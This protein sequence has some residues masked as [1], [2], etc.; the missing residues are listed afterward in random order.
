MLIDTQ[1][2]YFNGL[3]L[4]VAVYDTWCRYAVAYFALSEKRNLKLTWRFLFISSTSSIK[5]HLSQCCR[6]LVTGS[7]CTP[8]HRVKRVDVKM[9]FV[10]LFCTFTYV[11]FWNQK[12]TSTLSISNNN[13]LNIFILYGGVKNKHF[14]C[15]FT[16]TGTL[17]VMYKIESTQI[18]TF[19][20]SKVILI[21]SFNT[22]VVKI[23]VK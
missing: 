22:V 14:K 18:M 11:N 4:S 10:L 13:K 7:G 5:S 17:G 21:K 20:K 6:I 1:V 15:D 9:I 2:R 19:L 12:T 23:L 3:I 16:G 8:E